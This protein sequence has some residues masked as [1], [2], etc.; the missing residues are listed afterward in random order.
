MEHGAGQDAGREAGAALVELAIIAPLLLLLIFGIIEFGLTLNHDVNLT[1]GV[2]EGA[3]PATMRA[4]PVPARPPR[5][6]R[7]SPGTTSASGPRPRCR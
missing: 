3:R 4:A 1:N 5:S 2:R 7:A 6:S